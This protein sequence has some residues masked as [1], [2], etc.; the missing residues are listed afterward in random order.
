L[1]L[2]IPDYV[3]ANKSMDKWLAQYTEFRGTREHNFLT[4]LIAAANTRDS[5][6][7]KSAIGEW[8][9]ISSLDSFKD[10]YLTKAFDLIGQEEGVDDDYT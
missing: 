7:F 1:Y 9:S 2:C 10:K 4:Q 6:G 5:D 8:Q 3:A